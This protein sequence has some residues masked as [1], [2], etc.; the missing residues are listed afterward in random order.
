M[1]TSNVLINVSRYVRVV[2]AL[3]LLFVIG[4]AA[5][6]QSADLDDIR[7]LTPAARLNLLRG[8]ERDRP[9]DPYIQLE[10]GLLF[11]Q[12]QNFAQSESYFRRVLDGSRRDWDLRQNASLGLANALMGQ[13]N[14]TGAIEV[15]EALPQRRRTVSLELVLARSHGLLQQWQPAVRAYRDI[16]S[17]VGNEVTVNDY[18]LYAEAEFVSGAV[19]RAE[20]IILQEFRR[21]GFSSGMGLRLSTIAESRQAIPDSLLYAFLDAWHAS[22]LVGGSP[23]ATQ[24]VLQQLAQRYRDVAQVSDTVVYLNAILARDWTRADE[25]GR[26]I[27]HPVTADVLPLLVGAQARPDAEE[28]IRTLLTSTA[29]WVAFAPYYIVLFDV[30]QQTPEYRFSVMRNVFESAVAFGPDSAVARR[31][32]EEIARLTDVPSDDANLIRT[33]GEL[34]HL[35]LHAVAGGALDVTI[36]P[37]LGVLSLPEHPYTAVAFTIL[38]DLTRIE[39][40]R[41]YVAFEVERRGNRA[42]SGRVAALL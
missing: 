33:Q 29:Q 20:S 31:A 32:R 15:V 28:S 40:I 14:P 7:Q 17:D 23:E 11:G 41:Q 30:L 24:D 39:R 13:G 16:W 6:S 34:R 10:L 1:I 25:L 27:T 26:T 9:N 21:Y 35:G 12:L 5:M 8:M 22:V 19:D 42:L 2:C 38:Q 18:R 36:D 3:M 4:D 37:F